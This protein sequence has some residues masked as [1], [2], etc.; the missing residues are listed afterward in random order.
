M[1]DV[2]RW[3]GSMALFCCVSSHQRT[4]L[5]SSLQGLGRLGEGWQSG[6]IAAPLALYVKTLLEVC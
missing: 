5:G 4:V 2:G 6:V 1:F 3:L